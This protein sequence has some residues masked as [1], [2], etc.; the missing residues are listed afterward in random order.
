MSG[1]S[2]PWPSTRSGSALT[3]SYIQYTFRS[4]CGSIMCWGAI[5]YGGKSKLVWFDT[6][7]STSKRKGVNAAI[8]RTQVTEK[9]LFDCWKRVKA[10]WR[11][12]GLPW[13]VE[14]NAVVHTA[15]ATRGKAE[16]LGMRFL[17]HPPCSPCLNPIENLWSNLKRRLARLNP[18]PTTQEA[19]FAAAS[20]LWDAY[21][22]GEI[23]RLIMSMPHRM[24]ATIS[25]NGGHIKY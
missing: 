13:V 6:S 11:G 15:K 7:E 21:D 19:L 10:Q 5:W 14:D 4:S 8:Y 23:D 25:A 20:E 1:E 22:Q 2:C 3:P 17:P 18:R 24:K 12:Y 9:E 16:Q